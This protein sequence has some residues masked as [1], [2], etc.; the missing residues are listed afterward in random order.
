[1]IKIEQK[2][3]RREG[4]KESLSG[5]RLTFGSF[6]YNITLQSRGRNRFA[7]SSRQLAANNCGGLA[8]NQVSIELFSISR[9]RRDAANHQPSGAATA[10]QGG[11]THHHR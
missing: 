10:N 1:M 8:S 4:E 9:S 3:K 11:P 7:R 5:N 6:T 2:R